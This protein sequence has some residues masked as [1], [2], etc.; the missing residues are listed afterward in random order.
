MA[1]ADSLPPGVV[2]LSGFGAVGSSTRQ[3]IEQVIDTGTCDKLEWRKGNLEFA[4]R[5]AL[6][7]VWGIGPKTGEQSWQDERLQK[8]EY[9]RLRVYPYSRGSRQQ[10]SHNFR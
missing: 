3:K 1:L 4:A 8:H 7:K 2:N 10:A 6:C 9:A 5:S